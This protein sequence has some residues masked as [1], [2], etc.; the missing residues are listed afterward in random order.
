M[1]VAPVQYELVFVHIQDA[2]VC[3]SELSGRTITE[4]GMDLIFKQFC[5]GK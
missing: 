3:I 5:V 1:L 2:L 4:K